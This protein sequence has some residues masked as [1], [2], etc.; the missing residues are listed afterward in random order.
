MAEGRA[1]DMI[2]Q[3]DATS[4][5]MLSRSSGAYFPRRYLTD[6][7]RLVGERADL[8]EVVTY[9]DL[10]WQDGDDA[11]AMYPKEWAAWQADLAAGR[12]DRGKIHLLVQYDVDSRPERT[13]ALLRDPAHRAVP[14]NIMVFNRR[15]DRRGLMSTGEVR[16]TDYEIDEPYLRALQAEGFLV[17]YH[18]NANEQACFDRTRALEILNDDIADLRRRFSL[19]FMSAHGGV[20]GPDKLNNRDLPYE[21]RWHGDMIWVHNGRSPRFAAT[22]SDGG[23]N[24]SKIEPADRDLRDFVQRMKPG[25][26]YR[27]LLHPQYYDWPF[28]QSQRFTGTPWYDSMAAIAREDGHASLWSDVAEALPPRREVVALGDIRPGFAERVKSWWRRRAA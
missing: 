12:R 11:E 7:Y 16:F 24:R 1:M 22:F 21:P 20:A 10:P 9:A 19:R 25:Q 15:I 4:D 3:P 23:H 8:F 26:R 13:L 27:I 17:G 2:E 5:D 14:A 6:L 28:G 18:I